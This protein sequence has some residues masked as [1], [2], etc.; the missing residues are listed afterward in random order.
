MNIEAIARDPAA[1]VDTGKHLAMPSTQRG[2]V[3]SIFRPLPKISKANGKPPARA[4]WTPRPYR[5]VREETPPIVIPP[6]RLS[7][8]YAT[9]DTLKFSRP[10]S[11]GNLS[12]S[13]YSSAS[14]KEELAKAVKKQ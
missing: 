8:A 10:E 6:P 1:N 7:K 2:P 4:L 14:W 13:Y 3:A 11:T 9:S 5:M 12:A